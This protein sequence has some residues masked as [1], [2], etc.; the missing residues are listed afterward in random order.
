[1]LNALLKDLGYPR[2]LPGRDGNSPEFADV[3]WSHT[4]AYA[5]GFNSIYLNLAGRERAGIV[6]AAKAADTCADII[7][8]LEATA[9]GETG[10]HPT[11]RVH[12]GTEAYGGLRSADCPDLIAGYARGY[13]GSFPSASGRVSGAPIEP[14]RSFWS[15]DHMM[16]P[17]EVPGVLLSSDRRLD[18]PG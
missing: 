4:R 17:S 7:R 10:R 18:A 9:D 3:D 8:A 5:V 2:L 1:N 12:L 6:P 11:P 15:G 14:N 16:E 13:R